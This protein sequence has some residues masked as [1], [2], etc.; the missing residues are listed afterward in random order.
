M[1]KRMMVMAITAA[2]AIVASVYGVSSAAEF[3][4]SGAQGLW[5]TH[6]EV[7]KSDTPP[8][9][10]REGMESTYSSIPPTGVQ[11][12]GDEHRYGFNLTKPEKGMDYL[13]RS[14]PPTGVQGLWPSDPGL[15]CG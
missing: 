13:D 3:E 7:C 12:L 11:G 15:R 14:N 1:E 10:S 4:R 5:S 8:A 6:M 9:E 2:M